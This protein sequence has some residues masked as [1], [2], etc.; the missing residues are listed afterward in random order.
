L[1]I[2]P[3]EAAGG[4]RSRPAAGKL[5][6]HADFKI[7]IWY[8][9][10]DPL[11]TFRYQIYDVR[12]GEYPAAAD[13]WIKD[14]ETKYPAYLVVVR[15]V[16]LRRE[17][18]ETEKL[19]VGSVI[20]RELMVAAARSGVLLGGPLTIGPGPSSTGLSPAPRVQPMPAPDRSF[21][22][23]SPNPLV[24]PVYPRTRPP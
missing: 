4:P 19:K 7:L 24:I 6:D 8:R 14:I 22:N 3:G 21:L 10:D 1:A 12:K 2:G 20:H 13:A 18:G 11:A 9:R 15:T 17:R 5:A 16:D 23:P